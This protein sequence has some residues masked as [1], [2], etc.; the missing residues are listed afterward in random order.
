MI[1]NNFN[2]VGDLILFLIEVV[3][4]KLAEKKEGGKELKKIEN[5]NINEI[6]NKRG[7]RKKRKTKR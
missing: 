6:V 3:L 1:S 5:K 7:K 4:T 2:L